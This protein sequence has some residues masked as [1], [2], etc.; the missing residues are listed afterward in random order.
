MRNK[1][2]FFAT[3]FAAIAIA[4]AAAENVPAN[5]NGAIRCAYS[6]DVAARPRLRGVMSPGGDM[7]EEA[8]KTLGEWGVTLLRFQM[9]RDWHG[10]NGNQD[11]DEY[12]RWLDGRL[13]HFDTVVLPL[14]AKYGIMVVLDLHVP[15]GG[16]DASHEANMFHDARFG[17]HFVEIWRRIARRFK[18]R[19]GIYG[20]DLIN[21]PLQSHEAL[22][23]YDFQSLMRRAAEAVRAEDPLTPIVIESN[24]CA[25]PSKFDELEPLPLVN[26]IYQFHVYWPWEFTHQRVLG[27]RMWTVEWP[28]VSHGWTKDAIAWTLDRVI[29]FQKKYGARVYAG[30]FSSVVWAPG[31]EN[32]LRDCISL[33]ED[34]G[35]DWT[36]HA[37]REWA[38]WSVEHEGEDDASLRPS[39]DNPRKQ[40]L[41]EGFRK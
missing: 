30:E 13:D 18:G 28:D 5:P 12:D 9:V 20:Y 39:A 7:N 41:L 8:F 23:G 16:Y 14:A 6:A 19:E 35:W 38:G 26:V 11:L 36:Y 24:N 2:F 27:Y 15:P 40:A 22:P 10:V 17:D 37:F 1:S 4:V 33:F 31:A 21:E 29:K 32:Y 3:I 25:S 34:N